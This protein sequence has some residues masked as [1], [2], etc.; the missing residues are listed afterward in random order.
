[1]RPTAIRSI[2]GGLAGTTAMTVMMYVVAPMMGIHMDIAKML[3]SM[4]GNSWSA[5][6]IMHFINGTVLFP[7]AFVTVLYNRLPGPPI[8]KGTAWG[9]I[10][11]L[12]AQTV[13]MPMMGAGF[14]SLATGGI[15]PA[16]ASL[17]GHL[18]YGAI[19]GTTAANPEPVAVG[20]I[21]WR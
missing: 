11:W 2:A 10:L 18:L 13:V 20:S 9:L 17:V 19:L 12:L 7:I 16:M 5:G 3:G 8:L 4:L 14:F 15:M 1:M 21:A 6:L